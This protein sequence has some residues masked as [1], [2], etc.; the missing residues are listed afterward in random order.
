LRR[1]V[2]RMQARPHLVRSQAN[3]HLHN[4]CFTA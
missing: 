4:K 3:L 2:Q 1:A